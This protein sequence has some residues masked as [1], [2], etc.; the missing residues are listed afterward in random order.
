VPSGKTLSAGR[1][2][3]VAMRLV[4][5]REKE[6]EAFVPVESWKVRVKFDKNLVA[7]LTKVKGKTP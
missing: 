1:V 6:I 5:D 2:Q 3:S 7:E 4:V